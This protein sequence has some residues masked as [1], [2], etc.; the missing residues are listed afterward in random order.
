MKLWIASAV[1]MFA[2]VGHAGR[3]E[4]SYY[5]GSQLLEWCESDSGTLQLGC[6]GYLAGIS[7]V[8]ET[9]DA[10]GLLRKR[11]FCT[12]QHVSL[13]QLQKVAIKGLNEKPEKLHL[14]ASD[15]VANIFAEAFPCD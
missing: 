7:D 12:P 3:A 14:E 8:T 1:L 5:I 13:G 11:D 15:L 6:A 2:A 4:A 9:Y 10:W